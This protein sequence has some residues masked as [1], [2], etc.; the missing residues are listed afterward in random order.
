[1]T[2]G[3][4]AFRNSMVKGQNAGYQ[5]FSPFP[6]M[7]FNPIKHKNHHLS[8]I[9]FVSHK[10]FQFVSFH[11]LVMSE[12]TEIFENIGG[13]E[14]NAGNQHFLLFPQGFLPFAKKKKKEKQEGHDGPESLT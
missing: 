8:Y 4:K 10:C 7:F 14:E 1:M 11:G 5:Y 12:P 6:K 3:R 9:Y 2:L 13:K